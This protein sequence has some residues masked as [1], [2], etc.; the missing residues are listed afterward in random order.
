MSYTNA[1]FFLDYEG[2]S[3]A[4]RTA[5]TSCTAS[6]PSGTITRINKTAHGLVTGAVVDL[7][8]FTAWLNAAWKITVVDADNFD[9]DGAVWQATA[10]ASGTATPRGGS[11]KSDAWKT[12]VTGATS[13]RH[14]AGDTIRI[15]ASPDPTLVGNA[16]WT[17]ASKTITLAGAVTANIADCETAWTASANV[18]A[19]A[20]TAQFKENTKSAKLAIAAGFTTGLIAY[21]ATG[22]LNLSAYQQVSFWVFNTAALAASTLSLR[23]CSDAAGVTT[24]HTIAIP[25]NP[26]NNIWQAVTVD[27]GSALNSAIASVALYADLDP[28]TTTIQLDNII[29]CKAPSSADSLDLNSLI[30]KVWNLNWV[31]SATYATNDIRIPTQANRNGYRFKVTAGGGGAAGSTEPTWPQEIGATVTD[32][33]L[34]WTCEGLE[35]T[36]HGIQSINGTTVKL[37]G[38]AGTL[39]NAGRGY[40]GTTETVATYKRQPIVTPALNNGV[41][42]AVQ[43]SGTAAAPITYS[44]GWNRTDMTTRTG[45]TWF[46]IRN[47]SGYIIYAGAS[48][49]CTYNGISGSRSTHGLY[50]SDAGASQ[51]NWVQNVHMNNM[52]GWGV[53]QQ[54]MHHW[55]GVCMSGNIGA[56]GGVWLAGG[57]C[58]G[59]IKAMSCCG[60]ISNS[61]IYIETGYSHL[62][63]LTDIVSKNNSA[64]GLNRSGSAY[65]YDKITG[66]V[67]ADNASG[68]V[69]WTTND[70]YLNNCSFSEATVFAAM[71]GSLNAYIYSNKHNQVADSHLI[72]TDGGTIVSATDQRHTASGISW[73]FRPTSTQR[74]D[75]YP[76]R[77]SLAKLA[78][79]ANVAVTAQIWTRRDSANIKGQ[80]IAYGGQLAGVQTQTIDCQPTINT[81]VQSSALTFTPTEAGVVEIVF[82]VYDGVGTSNSFWIDDL[83]VA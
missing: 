28:G 60:G 25:A 75:H 66:L 59:S 29:A 2:G 18:T 78:C 40:S 1:V 8:A 34:T 32:G 12:F 56:N 14:A 22:T 33:A 72:T 35:E 44:G 74:A 46:S 45:D 24:V 7:T 81:W 73:K 42:H 41:L 64:Y 27:T 17:N 43:R 57:H 67:T 6:N 58:R 63:K 39:G 79:A 55:Q 4:A 54:S 13:A 52:G 9:L 62:L 21:F 50:M 3:D 20:D 71:T 53:I 16:T 37:D 76:L 19:T 48:G 26:A 23:L 82:E 83:T 61:G 77:L 5:L 49:Y 38:H 65:P 11:S 80:L 70:L 10:D 15:M 51:A 69:N 36:W 30:G 68:A 47:G 31:A